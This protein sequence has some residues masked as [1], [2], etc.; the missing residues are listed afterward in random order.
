MNKKTNND[1]V[2]L[3]KIQ[4]TE[5]QF[6]QVSVNDT[7]IDFKKEAQFA[8][9]ALQKNSYLMDTAL[10]NP[11][12]LQ[13]AVINIATIGLSLNPAE[14][15][16]YL[17]PRDGTVCLDISYMGLIHLAIESGGIKWAQA[18]LVHESDEYSYKGLGEKPEHSFNPFKDRGKIIGVYVVAKTKDDEYM[19]DQM[20]LQDVH[21]I[22]DR[23]Q[24]WK[25]LKAGK[26]KSCPWSTDEGEMIKKTV[27]KRAY[28]T[29]PKSSKRMGVAVQYLDQHEGINYL[30]E[31]KLDPATEEQIKNLKEMIA[32]LGRSEEKFIK[33]ISN[34]VG[35]SINAIHELNTKEAQ[36][37]TSQLQTMIENQKRK[38]GENVQPSN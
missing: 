30:E 25:A 38:S 27:I 14:K 4:D 26:I 15:K 2:V 1:I 35:R 17:V 10:K 19:V 16:A 36:T 28:K 20:S 37:A 32:A 29:W 7:A 9:Q 8:L 3:G 33:Y 23:T 11:D 13:N 12:S 6:N 5:T 31:Q 34:V 21:K 18:E 24:V 22:R